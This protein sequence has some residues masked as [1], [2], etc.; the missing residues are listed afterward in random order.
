MRLRL[1]PLLVL[2]VFVPAC[3]MNSP[4]TPPP[5]DLTEGLKELGEVYKYRATQNIPAPASVEDLVNHEP[6]LPNAWPAI[7]DGR[8]VI[9]WK[10]GYTPSSNNLLAYEKD[11][12]TNGGNV[13]L[14]N[15]TV[16]QMTA[17]EFRAAKK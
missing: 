17:D 14:R 3:G 13:L 9:L 7:Q 11:A 8:I 15:G 12:P 16:K 6:A 2:A 1:V 5:P 10:L 4:P